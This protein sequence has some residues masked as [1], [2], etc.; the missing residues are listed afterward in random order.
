MSLQDDLIA[1][2]LPVSGTAVQGTTVLFTRPLTQQET[3]VYERI[4]N[5][6]EYRRAAARVDANAIPNWA[7]WAQA[8]WDTYFNANLA[9]SNVT[10]IANLADAKVMLAK[11]NAVIN[12]LA[13]M[14]IAVRDH[15]RI[16]E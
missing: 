6:A 3:L 15:T 12:A 7:T 5:P 8:D 9:N 14:V 1:A 10:A 2:G 11:Q 16:I 4:I 13:K